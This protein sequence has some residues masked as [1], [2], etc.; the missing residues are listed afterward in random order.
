MPLPRCWV[1]SPK[2]GSGDG[3][4]AASRTALFRQT[5]FLPQLESDIHPDKS[6]MYFKKHIYKPRFRFT[7]RLLKDIEKGINVGHLGFFFGTRLSNWSN[8]CLWLN[9]F[10]AQAIFLF[11]CGCHTPQ[12]C[13]HL[14]LLA[15]IGQMHKHCR[16]SATK[17]VIDGKVLCVWVLAERVGMRESLSGLTRWQPLK[18]ASVSGRWRGGLWESVTDGQDNLSEKSPLKVSQWH[19]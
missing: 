11:H 3:T 18:W 16:A 5:H 10:D 2:F 9:H 1:S 7:L 17:P 19:H 15:F 8:C 6:E 14:T 12:N 13:L 4:G